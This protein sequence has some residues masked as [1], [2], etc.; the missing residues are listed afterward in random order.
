MRILQVL[1]GIATRIGG[2]PVYVVEGSLA[3]CENGIE[4]TVFTTDMAKAPG[5]RP[6]RRL[7]PDDLPSGSERIDLHVFPTKRPYRLAFSPALDAGISRRIADFDLIHIHG[8][9]LFHAFS[10]FRH[11]VRQD[12]SYIVSPHGA[13][14]PYL[15]RR[16]RGRKALTNLFWQQRM[17]ERASALHLMT[18]EEVRLMRDVA[19]RVRRI[20]VPSGV[21][22]ET[23]KDLPDGR[24]F[25]ERF[26]DGHD[27]PLVLFL[28]RI[29]YK[30]GIDILIRAFVEVAREISAAR[31][32]VA[33][34]DDERLTPRLEAVARSEGLAERVLFTGPL[35]GEQRL[36][37]LSA[38]DVWALSSHTE[39]L[40]I[41]VLEALAAGLPVVISPQVNIADE[42]AAHEAGVLAPCDPK[43]F[44]QALKG[45]LADHPQ[46]LRLG[47]RAQR[48]AAQYD[49]AAVGPRLAEMYRSVRSA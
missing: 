7:R 13:L 24:L 1:P 26:V 27:G 16:S 8:L 10:A 14:D 44:G 40:G 28:G 32:V 30:K 41:A 49:W 5:G 38:A 6:F 12:V 19:P 25:R 18:A 46:R 3:L 35:Y 2:P 17:L 45:L 48:F 21:R 42:V 36:A 23:F 31:L 39:N 11:A 47:P 37:A 9:W 34:P 33:G 4:S 20:V 29:N 15:R 43:R 22:C